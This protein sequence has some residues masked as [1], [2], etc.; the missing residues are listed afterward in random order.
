MKEQGFSPD[1]IFCKWADNNRIPI[2]KVG[3]KRTFAVI[4]KNINS[5]KPWVIIDIKAIVTSIVM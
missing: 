4:G 2:K 3:E 1:K 5:V